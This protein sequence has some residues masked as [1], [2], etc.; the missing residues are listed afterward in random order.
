MSKVVDAGTQSHRM[1]TAVAVVAAAVA[2]VSLSALLVVTSGARTATVTSQALE[3]SNA[4]SAASAA[5]RAANSQALVFAVDFEL[6]V[7]S[8]QAKSIALAE[9]KNT[10]DA[11][12]VV[13]AAPPSGAKKQSILIVIRDLEKA[14]GDTIE[15][16]EGGDLVEADRL[17]SDVFARAYRDASGILSVQQTAFAIAVL[18]ADGIAAKF[19]SITQVLITLLIPMLAV[20]TYRRVEARRRRERKIVFEARLAAEKQYSTSKD[21]FFD[22]I[23]HELRTPLT[24]IYGLSAHLVEHGLDDVDEAEEL[25]SMI[26]RDSAELFRMVEDLLMAARL[27]AGLVDVD[28]GSVDVR[29]LFDGIV[30]SLGRSASSV[31]VEGTASAR[32]EHRFLTH[33]A[34]NLLSN[35][36]THGGGEVLV[37]IE[38]H[39]PTVSITVADDGPGVDAA[40]VDTLF[41]PFVH[42]GSEVL[43]V[44]SVGLGLAVARLLI[45]AMGG[46][47]QYSRTGGWTVFTATLRAYQSDVGLQDRTAPPDPFA[48]V[49]EGGTASPGQIAVGA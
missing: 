26:H 43:L 21:E 24:A 40:K 8:P 9:A 35:A 31:R 38:E 48:P 27:D 4:V 22:G 47:I 25:I 14:A 29:A 44:G 13:A 23:S 3:W 5:T 34:R 41:T 45:E 10:L 30:G 37:T 1:A 20:V 16:I 7:A 39:G 2:I 6:G 33:V 36:S 32:A 11:L 17:H 19:E 49:S 12:T 42:D 18:D 46:T 28:L 15:A